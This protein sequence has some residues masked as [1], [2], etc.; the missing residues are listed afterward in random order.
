[1]IPSGLSRTS[2]A[3]HRYPIR[4]SHR[5][6]SFFNVLW[7]SVSPGM[8]Q[9][10]AVSHNGGELPRRNVAGKPVVGGT[11]PTGP[12]PSRRPPA[13]RVAPFLEDRNERQSGKHDVSLH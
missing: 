5:H 6:A 2:A 11:I 12:T 7:S 8:R 4:Y 13:P 9:S 10:F 1:M 3:M